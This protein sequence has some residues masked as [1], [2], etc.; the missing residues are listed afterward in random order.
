VGKDKYS[1]FTEATVNHR[2][3]D[4]NSEHEKWGQLELERFDHYQLFRFGQNA[5]TPLSKKHN[6][7]FVIFITSAFS[8]NK[9]QALITFIL[10]RAAGVDA[11]MI[12]VRTVEQIFINTLVNIWKRTK[13]KTKSTTNRYLLL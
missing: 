11:L 7:N 10:V 8:I 9:V 2:Y 5:T 6:F 4:K 13:K 3:S 1:K 12:L